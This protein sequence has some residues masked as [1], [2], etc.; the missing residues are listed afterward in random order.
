MTI[1]N[2]S[3]D[4]WY[5]AWFEDLTLHGRLLYVYAFT[6][7]HANSAGLYAISLKRIA[8]E[9][10]MSV[11]EVQAA[12]GEL[13]D[14]LTYFPE[15]GLLWVRGFLEHQANSPVFLRGL[16]S[17]LRAVKDPSLVQEF[18]TYNGGTRASCMAQRFPQEWASVRE[19]FLNPSGSIE[20]LPQARAKASAK[21]RAKGFRTI[22]ST[23]AI[24]GEVAGVVDQFRAV[25]GVV[26]SPKDGKILAGLVGRHGAAE[27]LRRLDAQAPA[28]GAADSP[29]L[30]FAKGFSGAR[31]ASPE[32][33]LEAK[34]RRY[35]EGLE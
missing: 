2:V 21:A 20:E 1:R 5:Q 8:S 16:A 18:L 32:E 7:R 24:T 17:I 4:L 31:R 15:Q 10:G 34:A 12:L 25:P 13:R 29:L 30:F 9:T 14:R 22:E 11:E 35:A 3:T 28:I 6:N 26:P 23:R 27:V 33:S 19:S